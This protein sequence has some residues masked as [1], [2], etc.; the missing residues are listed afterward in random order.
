MDDRIG[1]I[2]KM[3]GVK[4]RSS[5]NPKKR[6]TLAPGCS[7]ASRRAMRSVSDS[8]AASAPGR[9]ATSVDASMPVPVPAPG[10]A[11]GPAP[12]AGPAVTPDAPPSSRAASV[13]RIGG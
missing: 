1:I 12:V 7:V 9:P 13:F 3:Q 11:P 8:N 6:A 10:P 2:G 4:P 5:P